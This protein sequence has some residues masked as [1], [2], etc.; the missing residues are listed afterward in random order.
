MIM[1]QHILFPVAVFLFFIWSGN[2]IVVH[3]VAICYGK[4]KLHRKTSAP[5]SATGFPGVSILKPLV[6]VDPNLTS[7][8]ETFFTMNYP[9]FEILFCIHEDGD[10]SIKIVEQLRKKYPHVD[11]QV[12]IGG[13]KIGANPKI[14]NMFPG[15][16]AAK[17]D[18][19]LISDSGIR[20]KEDTLMDMVQH[21]TDRVGLVHQMPFVCDRKGFPAAVEKEFFGT[22]HARFYLS[23]EFYGINCCTGMSSLV[24]R[25]I[26]E[27]VGGLQTFSCYL[28]EDYFIACAVLSK[29]YKLTIS[30]QPAW[31]NAGSLQISAFQARVTRSVSTINIFYSKAF[32]PSWARLRYAMLPHTMILEP[33]GECL[34][35]GLMGAWAAH[36]LF[37]WSLLA[38]FLLHALIWFILDWI[39]LSIVNRGGMP[40]NKFEFLICWIFRESSVPYLYLL[41]LCVP[42]IRWRTGTYRLRWG[43]KVNE[44][45]SDI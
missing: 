41:A 8:L 25:S 10:P 42:A 22:V 29:G 26:L 33:V 2:W 31:Q 37:G 11:C 28:A 36:I 7:N 19:L 3:L 18:L 38:F 20:M 1:W 39:L 44:A 30:S 24:R 5:P 12:F 40:M 15:Y 27:D 6:G 35:M 14:N 43:G 9:Q 45:T 32:Y 13:E 34:F 21:M 17:Y 23:A 16:K 4:W